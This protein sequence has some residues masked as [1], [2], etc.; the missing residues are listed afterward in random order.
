MNNPLPEPCH[1]ELTA[2]L[3]HQSAELDGIITYLIEIKAA[4]VGN[5]TESLNALITQPRLPIAEVDKFETQHNL[6]L[7]RYGFTH[8]RDG[9][10]KCIA[11]CD[12]DEV[13]SQQYEAFQQTLLRLQHTIQINSLL[14]SKGR[15]RVRKSL[16]LIMGQPAS[17]GMT[18]YSSSGRTED[19]D[20]H[21]T[22]A[23]A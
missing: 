4:I 18:T 15:E 21:R 1:A 17:N 10:T 14:V 9:L 11:W 19:N 6:L 8:D 5:D 20:S 2:L 3:T 22:I 12:K 13:I 23:R 16:H 7:E